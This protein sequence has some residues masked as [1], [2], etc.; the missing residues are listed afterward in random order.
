MEE[1][2]EEMC[3]TEFET[4]KQLNPLQFQRIEKAKTPDKTKAPNERLMS[5]L[6]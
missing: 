2:S 5:A 1:L 6:R 4:I 3:K